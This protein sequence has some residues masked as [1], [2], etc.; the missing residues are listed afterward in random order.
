MTKLGMGNNRA[1]HLFAVHVF[2]VDSKANQNRTRRYQLCLRQRTPCLI[3]ERRL[4]I[5]RRND[6]DVLLLSRK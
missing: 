6:E 3:T 4:S 5:Q 1:D 2:N